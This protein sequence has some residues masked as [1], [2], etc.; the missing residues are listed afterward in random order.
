ML[1]QLFMLSQ[2]VVLIVTFIATWKVT[3]KT[4]VLQVIPGSYASGTK[5]GLHELVNLRLCEKNMRG[6]QAFKPG[7]SCLWYTEKK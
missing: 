1:L 3:N 5:H 2:V 6:H 4:L 7:I